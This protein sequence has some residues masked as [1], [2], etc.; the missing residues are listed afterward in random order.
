MQESPCEDLRM[1]ATQWEIRPG[2]WRK[3]GEEREIGKETETIM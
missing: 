2:G 3:V 1:K